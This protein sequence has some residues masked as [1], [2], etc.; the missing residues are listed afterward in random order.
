MVR[1]AYIILPVYALFF[2]PVTAVYGLAADNTHVL[3]DNPLEVFI[4]KPDSAIF[5][6]KLA[7]GLGARYF[8]PGRVHGRFRWRLFARSRVIG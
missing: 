3:L 6:D 4:H 5:D 2:G 1:F 8:V 7:S